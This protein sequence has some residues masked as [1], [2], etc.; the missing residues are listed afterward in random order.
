MKQAAKE[1]KEAAASG[2][3][4]RIGTAIHWWTEQH[5]RGQLA[6]AGQVSEEYEAMLDAYAD[7]TAAAG[8]EVVDTELFVVCD[9][10]GVAGTLDR[11]YRLPDGR[12][13]VGD[14]KTGKHAASYGAQSVAIQTAVYA[15]SER[16]DP[17][18]GQRSPLH[19]DLDTRLTVLVHLPIPEML[20]PAQ[21]N[22]VYLDARLGW[23]GAQL[24]D[25]VLEWRKTDVKF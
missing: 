11:L 8:L 24:A 15:H 18:T 13:V 16:Y 14:I 25:K 6:I 7:T 4:A 17:N 12:V 19:P 1:A 22:I 9:E 10:L 5:D 23:Y 3:S 21:C 2:E 20:E